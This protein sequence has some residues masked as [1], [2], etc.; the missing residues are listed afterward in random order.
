M[1]DD[2]VPHEGTTALQ[3][4]PL[5]SIWRK[6]EKAR[7]DEGRTEENEEEKNQKME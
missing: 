1:H 4:R 7:E 2:E 3:K 6:M 5:L